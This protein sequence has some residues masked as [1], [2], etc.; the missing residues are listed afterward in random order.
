MA[1]AKVTHEQARKWVEELTVSMPSWRRYL[2]RY[3]DEQATAE[4]QG[5]EAGRP[6]VDLA[7]WCSVDA[8]ARRLACNEYATGRWKVWAEWNDDAIESG[9]GVTADEAAVDLCDKL[10]TRHPS[11][12]LPKRP[13]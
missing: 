12:A 13:T 1:E 8:K 6:W 9:S 7:H 3:V 5:K 2:V 11:S 10:A 4:Q